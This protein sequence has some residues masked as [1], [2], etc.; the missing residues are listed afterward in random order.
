MF[1][2]SALSTP[3]YDA[4]LIG[5]ARQTPQPDVLFDASASYSAGAAA[6]ARSKLINNDGW[7][8]TDGG[9]AP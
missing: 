2:E 7:R 8:I 6:T 3:N 9:Q 5:W 4:L 1:L